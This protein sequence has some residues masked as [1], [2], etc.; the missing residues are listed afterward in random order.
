[1]NLQFFCPAA[2][3]HIDS[4]IEVDEQT[5]QTVKLRIISVPCPHCR[6]A[7]RFLLADGKLMADK[8]QSEED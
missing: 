8:I 7:H 3:R 5:F 2:G 1:M 4:G 6:C